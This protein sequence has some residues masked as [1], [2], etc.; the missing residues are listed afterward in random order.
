VETEIH[1]NLTNCFAP[2][3]LKPKLNGFKGL[4]CQ[5]SSH[6]DHWISFEH[7]NMQIRIHT[8]NGRYW[9]ILQLP[10][11]FESHKFIT[12]LLTYT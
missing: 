2:D 9:C 8:H 4:L 11:S 5:V 7:E 12:Y 10:G 3:L 6:S 1:K